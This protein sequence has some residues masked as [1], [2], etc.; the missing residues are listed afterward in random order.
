MSQSDAV[1]DLFSAL[2]KAQG[3]IKS[4]LK[5]STN[6]HYKSKYA[7][8]AS[9]W[10]ACRGP[11]SKNGLSVCQY[12]QNNETG[13][14]LV[15]QLSHVSGQWVRG[16]MPLLCARNDMQGLGS[17]ITYARRYSLAAMVGVAQD[18][19]DGNAAVSAAPMGIQQPQ[20]GDGNTAPVGYRIGFG[21]WKGRSLED[22]YNNFGPEKIADY[23]KYLELAAEKKGQ[24]LGDQARE[25]IAEAEKFLGAM[26]NRPQA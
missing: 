3:E 1:N 13:M 11:L 14:S 20:P 15:T 4:A 12:T 6:P 10:D 21:Q 9:V 18:D 7:D 8:L 24:A 22:C 23:I 17:A 5:D 16:E 25:F 2:A 26:E 19:D